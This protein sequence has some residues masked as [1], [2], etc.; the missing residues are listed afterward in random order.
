MISSQQKRC[1]IGIAHQ[2]GRAPFAGSFLKFTGIMQLCSVKKAIARLI[3]VRLIYVV[4]GEY[5]FTNPFFKAWL[6]EPKISVC[7]NSTR[8]TAVAFIQSRPS[9]R[10]PIRLMNPQRSK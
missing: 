9:A 3:N 10:T 7:N 8:P 5:K 4:G 6:I 1:L 2:G